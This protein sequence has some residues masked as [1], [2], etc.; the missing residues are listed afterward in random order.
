MSSEPARSAMVRA[1]LRMRWK[2]RADIDSWF[3]PEYKKVLDDSL[4][5]AKSYYL[6]SA[7][8]ALHFA[9]M[10]RHRQLLQQ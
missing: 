9:R 8:D 10:E 3:N 1:T 2:A 6:D 4:D 5:I 7:N